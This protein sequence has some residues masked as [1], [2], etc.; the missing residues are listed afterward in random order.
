ML[1]YAEDD[2]LSKVILVFK[3]FPSCF[4]GCETWPFPLKSG[5]NKVPSNVFRIINEIK[6]DKVRG[7]CR[8]VNNEEVT[9]SYRVTEIEVVRCWKLRC[10]EYVI[11]M[12]DQRNSYRNLWKIN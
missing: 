9:D 2:S 12:G 8:I 1:I 4:Y 11:R 6:K 7:P 10:V 5:S 3:S